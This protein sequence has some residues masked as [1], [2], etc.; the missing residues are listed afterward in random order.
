[1]ATGKSQEMGTTRKTPGW[2]SLAPRADP[3]PQQ[4]EGR[5]DATVSWAPIVSGRRAGL[6]K[7]PVGGR[8]SG[9]EGQ[10]RSATHRE[11]RRCFF[12]LTPFLGNQL[13]FFGMT[14]WA[15]GHSELLSP[16]EFFA[17]GGLL[18]SLPFEL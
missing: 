11:C 4:E 13:V 6:G 5:G 12:F 17:W 18:G 9:Q 8:L 3:Q 14:T 16:S 15:G 1:M 7:R 10:S 2:A